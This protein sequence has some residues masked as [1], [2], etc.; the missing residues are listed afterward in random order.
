MIN[1]KL[2]VQQVGGAAVIKQT[3]AQM[4]RLAPAARKAG[5]GVRNLN[6]GFGAL[7]KNIGGILTPLK[8]MFGQFLGFAAAGAAVSGA[9]RSVLGFNSAMT[10]SVAIMGE[11]GRELRGEME[12]VALTVAK[13]LNI[14][15]EE[16]AGSFFFL[17]SAGLDAKTSIEALPVVAT[18][19]KAGMF[20]MARATDL[21]TDAQS[22]LGLTLRDAETGMI[23][24]A[25]T[26]ANMAN[27]SDVL[28]KANTL[29]NATVEQFSEA[30][31]N[32]AGAAMRLLNVE[33]TEGVAVLAALADQGVK[34]AEAGTQLGIVLRNITTA[35]VK[36]KAEFQALGVNVF[37]AEG[38]FA[39]MANVIGDLEKA[40]GGLSDEQQ[41]A[42]L[43]QLGFA[44]RAQSTLLQL[45]GTSDAIRR[46]DA[47][48]Q[49]AGGTTR[50]VAEQQLTAFRERLG[51]IAETMKGRVIVGFAEFLKLM[52]AMGPVFRDIG[53]V[54]TTVGGL[55]KDTFVGAFDSLVEF[56]SGGAIK[57]FSK[58]ANALAVV[59]ESIA[60]AW[61]RAKQAIIG[62]SLEIAKA[63]RVSQE[64]EVGR[65]IS[66]SVGLAP[67]VAPP[68]S[69]PGASSGPTQSERLIIAEI[70]RL[71]E[72][73]NALISGNGGIA[74]RIAA[75]GR[76]IEFA[77]GDVGEGI[78]GPGGSGG[79]LSEGLKAEATA[80][81]KVVADM[82]RDLLMAKLDL[83]KALGEERR[84]VG[85]Q[86]FQPE[87]LKQARATLSLTSVEFSKMADRAHSAGVPIDEISRQLRDM[88]ASD[89]QIAEI[90]KRFEEVKEETFDWSGLLQDAANLM[91]VLGVEA[92][93][94]LGK[95]ISGGSALGSAI[96]NFTGA[97]A[98]GG[99][100][101]IASAGLSL[102]G[103]GASFIG[104]FFSGGEER[105]VNDMRDEFFSQWT[106]G[107]VGL[108]QELSAIGA[109]AEGLVRQIFDAETVE[110]YNAAVAQATGLLDEHQQQLAMQ[111]EA[112]NELNAA[113]ERYNFDITQTIF[114][115]EA[116]DEQGAQLLKEF[117]LLTQAGIDQGAVIEA[118]SDNMSAYI[119]SAL[120]SG[121]TIPE[122]MREQVEAF[123]AAGKL[124]DENGNAFASAEDAG[125]TFA[126]TTTEK[127]QG[128]IDSIQQLVNALL[129]IPPIDIPVSFNGGQGLPGLPG[130]APG[131]GAPG[132]STDGR[133]FP[134][135]GIPGF[136][137]GGLVDQPTFAMVGERGPEVVA[138]VASLFSQVSGG[139]VENLRPQIE[140]SQQVVTTRVDQ[141]ERALASM[142]EQQQQQQA[143]MVDALSRR[144]PILLQIDG[145]DV[146]A[147]VQEGLDT[148]EILVPDN[149]RTD[150]ID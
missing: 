38:K 19:A 112:R 139:V 132:G 70:Q 2:L 56:F 15:A 148:N 146:R 55:L 117:N 145:R 86:L 28:V 39:G 76:E 137:R 122:A 147:S 74:D 27:L 3:V 26:M 16:A 37:D 71:E 115:Q 83:T 101:G 72:E 20:D 18:F 118:M 25:R 54:L 32:R 95:M 43:I 62:V 30:L 33:V 141:L 99:P 63:N 60:L 78:G 40:L 106:N 90:A 82:S 4:Q 134:G 128:L 140:A 91:Q 24:T 130:G 66:G 14:A 142:L 53:A 44:D 96:Q 81:E 103:A 23:D 114:A 73:A 58:Q 100:A 125:I 75:S 10:Q 8:G 65:G 48:L 47:A 69:N 133:G 120:E 31:T 50:Q 57:N 127:M 121:A 59:G 52:K 131:G 49:V 29:A 150:R 1:V 88:G 34:G 64:S 119:Q 79:P 6:L 5:L 77:L 46:Y 80:V 102:L 138:P 11:A 67:G 107:F 68:V 108:Q 109:D 89:S 45:L 17:A 111:T 136:A 92:D 124:L 144:P 149:A 13:D 21:L 126:E 87:E 7:G 105:E 143:A 22:A 12:A 61:I 98:T 9:T 51:Q 97:L 41:K 84:S 94:F 113:L 135:S 116:L 110:Q 36:N 123:I 42:A 85:F 35:A 104:G 93:S 129:G